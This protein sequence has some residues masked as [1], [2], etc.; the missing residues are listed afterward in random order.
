M[1]SGQL[2]RLCQGKPLALALALGWGSAMLPG[3][4]MGIMCGVLGYDIW[5]LHWGLDSDMDPHLPMVSLE[6]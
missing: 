3:L 6:T 4:D 2:H 5:G 1:L